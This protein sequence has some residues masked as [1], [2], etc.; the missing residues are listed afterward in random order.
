VN[1]STTT[2]ADLERK[3]AEIKASI[4]FHKYGIISGHVAEEWHKRFD[5]VTQ[6]DG[7]RLAVRKK[8]LDKPN[9]KP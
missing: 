4:L 7:T 1:R 8:P 3:K 6:P 2:A 9:P 5:F